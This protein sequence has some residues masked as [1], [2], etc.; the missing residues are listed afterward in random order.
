[1]IRE[2]YVDAAFACA[3][4]SLGADVLWLRKVR[5]DAAI[6]PALARSRAV[7]TESLAAPYVA[8]A[9]DQG[10]RRYEA[11]YS[12]KCLKNRRRLLRRLE[13]TG[14]IA[15][16]HHHGGEAV[17][18]LVDTAFEMKRAWLAEK[19]LISSAIED[20]RAQAFF[21]AV[22][23]DEEATWVA[24]LTLD[25]KPIAIN[26][27]LEAANRVFAHIITYDLAHAKSGAGVLLMENCI[28]RAIDRGRLSFDLLAP[29]DPYKSDWA[30]LSVP[31]EDWCVA[32]TWRGWLYEHIYL[33]GARRLAKRLADSLP[34]GLRRW[35]ISERSRLWLQRGEGPAAS[36]TPT[37]ASDQA[38]VTPAP[39][40][41]APR[42]E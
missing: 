20:D 4:D 6:Q 16:E 5:A 17:A 30:D 22:A 7:S 26:I 8:L 41:P 34:T 10:P 14:K 36:A 39:K 27:M 40:G 37:K 15:F 21:R 18:R 11:L 19:G 33:G 24:A 28:R 12:A 3:R 1:M 9:D 42:P 32:L 31:V 29:A 25:G 2:S 23:C 38:G 35:L 13:E